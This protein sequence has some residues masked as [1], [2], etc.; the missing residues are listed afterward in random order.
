VKV[1]FKK[2]LVKGSGCLLP[3]TV[4]LSVRLGDCSV[5]VGFICKKPMMRGV[6]RPVHKIAKSDYF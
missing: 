4:V 3:Q 6:F 1:I 2:R 5:A